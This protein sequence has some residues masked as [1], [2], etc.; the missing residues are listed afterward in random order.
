MLKVKRSSRENGKVRGSCHL[1]SV[2]SLSEANCPH[3]SV[4][5][6]IPLHTTVPCLAKGFPVKLPKLIKE[7]WKPRVKMPTHSK[8]CSGTPV[9]T[10]SALINHCPCKHGANQAEDTCPVQ[11]VLACCCW[12]GVREN[13]PLGH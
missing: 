8:L 4:T 10:A 7:P 11:M 3:S 9:L 13:L 2:T 6:Q 12:L 1:S 5:V